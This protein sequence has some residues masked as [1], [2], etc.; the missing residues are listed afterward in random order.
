MTNSIQIPGDSV[1][2]P[3][4]AQDAAETDPWLS[5]V[6]CCLIPDEK[7]ARQLAV[8]DRGT[9]SRLHRPEKPPETSA[10]PLPRYMV[11]H[12][13]LKEY[14]FSPE[15]RMA[16]RL[17]TEEKLA[18]FF[19]R[20]PPNCAERSGTARIRSP[21]LPDQETGTLLAP[22]IAPNDPQ[23]R[24]QKIG[25]VFPA[26]GSGWPEFF[27]ELERS[28]AR[29][30]YAFRLRRYPWFNPEE[31]AQAIRAIRRECE[32][33]ILY[34][35]LKERSRELVRQLVEEKYPLILFDQCRLDAR[36]STVSLDHFH[37]AHQL[38][39]R[40]LELG[41][42]RPALIRVADRIPSAE[43]RAMGYIQALS[44]A[45]LKPGK[46]IYRIDENYTHDGIFE[47]IRNSRCDGL[48]FTTPG[49]LY[50][51]SFSAAPLVEFL[52]QRN[53]PTAAFD[54]KAEAFENR[55]F[56]RFSAVQPQRE[57]AARV[58][59]E[60]TLIMNSSVSHP[61]RILIA[62]NILARTELFP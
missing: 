3:E 11:L 45:G 47:F 42:R 10:S 28:V 49:V 36:C 23:S 44:E 15:G 24:Q 48:L 6:V 27:P 26:A 34:P 55:P 8:F 29:L 17:P 57:L 14:I 37:G 32:G 2:P 51:Y 54:L 43:E 18:V 16:G 5:W 62:P 38:T 61:T 59:A 31:E 30:G 1:P 4:I 22:E 33:M 53:L 35:G 56:L 52:R 9:F 21:H 58:I 20:Q 19:R 12:N 46:R 41:C 7:F 39:C 25:V 13:I 60:L 40:L 50:H